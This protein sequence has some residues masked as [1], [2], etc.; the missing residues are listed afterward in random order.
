M[1][2]RRLLIGG[3]IAFVLGNILV[4]IGSVA[5]Q[6]GIS[7]HFEGWWIFSRTVSDVTA[8][9]WAGIALILGGLTIGIIGIVGIILASILE[10]SDR[11]QK[12]LTTPT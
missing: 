2:H 11:P 9:Y 1:K 10:F 8:T 4:I 6:A 5:A 3:T 12:P 7:S